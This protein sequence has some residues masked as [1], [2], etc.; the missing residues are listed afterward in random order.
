MLPANPL[1]VI[2]I[3]AMDEKSGNA[4]LPD[5][6]QRFILELIQM[7]ATSTSGFGMPVTSIILTC[8]RID[9][10][11]NLPRSGFR[12]ASPSHRIDVVDFDDDEIDLLADRA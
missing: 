11:N 7:P 1:L 12:F 6:A 2:C 3:D 10:L 8:R 9:E 5:E 4:R